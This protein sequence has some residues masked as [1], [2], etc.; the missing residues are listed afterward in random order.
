[1]NQF[2][3]VYL[4]LG[5]NLGDRQ[6]FI[7]QAIEKLTINGPLIK[8]SNIF[9][10]EPVGIKNQPP[11]LNLITEF[12]TSLLLDHF[13]DNIVSIEEQLGR[14]RKEKGGPRTIDIDLIFFGNQIMHTENIKIPHPAY[15]QRKFV[16]VPMSEIAPKWICPLYHKSMK[17]MLSIC[18]D[19]SW[20]RLLKP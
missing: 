11:F 18:P 7:I 9:E 5:S 15:P 13:F 19:D 17:E 8:R 20:V 3:H 1:L 12:N 10:T 14:N 2:T 4:S 6:N 16:L